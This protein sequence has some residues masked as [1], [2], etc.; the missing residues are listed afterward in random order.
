MAK[1]QGPVWD[2]HAINAE[3]RRRG[4]TLTGIAKRAG[5]GEN[6]CRS[7]VLGGNRRGARAIATALGIPF[8]ELFPD[9]YLPYRPDDN[10][11]IPN[12]RVHGSAKAPHGADIRRGV[13]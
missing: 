2:R 8:R 11:P 13:A 3:V 6:A 12:V 1:P 5:L 9:E 4:M 10:E 7:G